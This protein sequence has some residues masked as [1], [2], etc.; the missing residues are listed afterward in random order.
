M[1]SLFIINQ[2]DHTKSIKEVHLNLWMVGKERFL[3]IGLMLEPNQVI[4]LYLPWNNAKIQ[5]LYDIML[6]VQV[7]NAIF[8]QHISINTD[9]GASHATV[10]RGKDNF[11]LIKVKDLNGENFKLLHST[12]NNSATKFTIEASKATENEAYIRIRARGFGE[13]VFSKIKIGV[14]QQLHCDFFLN[15]GEFCFTTTPTPP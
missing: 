10:S 7:L 6:D 11:D 9:S 12:G 13:N 5:D 1:N 2:N 15:V 8:N 4:E 14:L 3:D